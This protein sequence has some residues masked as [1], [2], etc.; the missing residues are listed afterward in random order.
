MMSTPRP[1]EAVSK[2]VHQMA[3]QMIK[4]YTHQLSKNAES[5][6]LLKQIG[7]LCMETWPIEG[8]LGWTSMATEADDPKPLGFW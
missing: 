2:L 8:G 4:E 5:M 7:I 1:S 3:Q 6:Q